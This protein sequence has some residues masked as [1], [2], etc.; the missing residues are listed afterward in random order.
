MSDEDVNY[1]CIQL[2]L[3]NYK[4]II[5]TYILIIILSSHKNR[6]IFHFG[7]S[8]YKLNT[9]LRD[10]EPNLLKSLDNLVMILI[11]IE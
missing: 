7:S 11:F 2:H 3:T 1:S 6:F 8:H 5:I 4:E 10:V 9:E